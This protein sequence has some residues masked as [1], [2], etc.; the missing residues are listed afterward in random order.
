MSVSGLQYTLKTIAQTAQELDVD[1][2]QGL[3]TTEVTIRQQHYGCN[4]VAAKT[5][6]WWNIL[7]RQFQSPFIYLLI[8]AAVLAAFLGEVVDA[9]MV[10]I[11]ILINV[12]LGFYQEFRSDQSL[13]LLRSYISSHASVWRDGHTQTLDV[14]ELVPGDVI[15]VETGD[16]IPADARVIETEGLLLNESVLTGESVA[17]A[18]QASVL[19][20]LPDDQYKADNIIFSGTTVVS[21]EGKAIIIATGKLT[22][23]GSIAKLTAETEKE[24]EFTKGIARFSS[25]IL[26][27][28]AV[29][30]VFIF[31]AN[32]LIKRGEVNI[33]ELMIFSIALAVSVIP[34]ALPVVSI[35]SFSRGAVRLAK[36][37]VVVR[38]LSAIEDLGGIEIL[39][40]DKTGTITENKLTVVEVSE[41]TST[42]KALLYAYL[43]SSLLRN[44]DSA[45]PFDQAVKAA[46]PA[47]RQT[48]AAIYTRLE[49]VPFDPVRRRN[50]ILVE[51]QKQFELIVRGASEEVLGCCRAAD[52][53]IYQAWLTQQGLLGRRVL[54]V[55]AKTLAQT[56]AGSLTEQEVNLTLVGFIAFEDPIKSTTKAAVSEARHLGIS[57][58]IIT[59]DAPEVAGAVA[60]TIDLIDDPKQ[61]ITGANFFKL[62]PAEQK[63]AAEQYSV[64][65]RFAPE[66]KH[67]IISLL[68]QTKA[69]GFLG[70]GIN[71]APALKAASVSLVVHGASDIA[72]ETADI[73][74]L[75]NSLAVIVN[76]IKEGREVFTNILKYIR[77]TLSSNFGNFY[78][79]AV[80]SLFINFLPMLPIQI[81]L[82]NLLSDFPMIAVATDTVSREEVARP[83]AFRIRD[84]ALIATLLGIISTIFDFLFFAL[85]YRTT[86]EI[87]QTNWFIGSILTE[88]V[89]L[90]SIRTHKFAFFAQRPSNYIIGLTVCAFVATILFPFTRFGHEFFRFV[91]PTRQ[92][93]LTILALTA[94][95]F[96]ISEVVKL[97]Y[98]RYLDS[99]HD[100]KT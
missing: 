21:G 47:D 14:I 24:S 13:K 49:E 32:L 41:A 88:L 94:L 59:G 97:L 22:A 74:L 90:F 96:V 87:L 66:D 63:T 53:A 17:V 91:T 40:T 48:T 52:V 26:R 8:G 79:V 57:V 85:Y 64:F 61:V 30:L 4:V 7:L 58:K 46:L 10:V 70:E 12:G 3:A 86:P 27:L 75:Q 82:L 60:K 62:K 35:F 15:E 78:A 33:G 54:A 99:R 71:D 11:F 34:E 72:R 76:G 89:F 38:R 1:I 51:H 67:H 6:H 37:K 43:G 20:Q 77:A 25:F 31:I 29:T 36:Q 5:L 55:A 73:I 19:T 45:D 69:V 42:P 23:V 16:I 81:L 50:S 83:Q 2:A 65:A 18:K 92:D 39:C 28:I 100:T 84:I 9:V 44:G 56:P 93:I 95:Y 68:Q 98:Y 80:A